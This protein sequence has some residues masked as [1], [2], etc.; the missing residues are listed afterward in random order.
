MPNSPYQH[1]PDHSYDQEYG[2]EDEIPEYE[3]ELEHD[4]DSNDDLFGDSYCSS[5]GH[6]N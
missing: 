4:D 3:A 2:A 6:K 1:G 5:K